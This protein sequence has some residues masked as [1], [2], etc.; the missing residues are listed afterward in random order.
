MR[1]LIWLSLLF[2]SLAGN[3]QS[4][5]LPQRKGMRQKLVVTDSTITKFK[6]LTDSVSKQQEIKAREDRISQKINYLR[7][8]NKKSSAERRKAFLYLGLGVL[9]L[10]ILII[11]LR[12]KAKK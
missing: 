11:G 10:V 4:D 1:K 8:L 9:F 6:Q 3:S 5:T 7:Q 2:I 12:R